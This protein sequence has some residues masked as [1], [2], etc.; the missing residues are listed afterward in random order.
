FFEMTVTTT[1]KSI[2]IMN[3]FSFM[4]ILFLKALLSN[5]LKVYLK[6]LRS[7]C[8]GFDFYEKNKK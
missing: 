8:D 6:I 2:Y 1:R 5:N 3:I 4:L 7:I